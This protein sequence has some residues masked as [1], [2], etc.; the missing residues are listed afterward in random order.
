MVEVSQFNLF[1][2]WCFSVMISASQLKIW[3][4]DIVS[5]EETQRFFMVPLIHQLHSLC[6]TTDDNFVIFLVS[7]KVVSFKRSENCPC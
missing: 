5:T 2:R 1:D 3:K 6:V 4:H 7:L